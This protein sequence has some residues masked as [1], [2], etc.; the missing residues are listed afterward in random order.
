MI[1]ADASL[2]SFRVVKIGEVKHPARGYSAF[3]FIPGTYDELIVA[4]KSEEKDGKPVASYV[5]V[6]DIDGKILM[7][8]TSLNDPHKF[9]GIAFVWPPYLLDELALSAPT[10]C[11]QFWYGI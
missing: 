11:A 6:F 9:E 8:D 10:Q 5:T 2:S 7:P 3:Q 4:L 1:I